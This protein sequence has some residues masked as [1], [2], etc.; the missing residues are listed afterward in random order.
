MPS[1]MC[2]IAVLVA[3]RSVHMERTCV[4]FLDGFRLVFV[5]SDLA[6]LMHLSEQGGVY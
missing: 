4:D 2:K 6:T 5:K 3:W 1:L